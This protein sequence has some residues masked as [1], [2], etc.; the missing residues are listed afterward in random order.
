MKIIDYNAD[1][2]IWQRAQLYCDM[3]ATYD[4]RMFK[5]RIR[6]NVQLNAKNVGESG[7]LQAFGVNPD[8]SKYN[9]RIVDPTEYIL[10]LN[11]EL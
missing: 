2:P 7:R 11:F 4:F 6:G 5:N 3:F 9:Y 8:G 10:S 1:R